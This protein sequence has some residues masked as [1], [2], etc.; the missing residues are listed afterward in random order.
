MEGCILWCAGHF[1]SC[2]ATRSNA[3]NVC[4]IKHIN[5]FSEISTTSCIRSF[6]DAWA[7]LGQPL[8]NSAQQMRR[9]HAKP[10]KIIRRQ[11]EVLNAYS[12]T[13]LQAMHLFSHSLKSMSSTNLKHFRRINSLP[14]DCRA[15]EWRLNENLHATHFR[16]QPSIRHTRQMLLRGFQTLLWR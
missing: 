10:F 13:H 14:P 4:N 9:D 11:Y 7:R 16:R 8:S 15:H 1:Y 3:A 6:A 12:R 5:D 2:R